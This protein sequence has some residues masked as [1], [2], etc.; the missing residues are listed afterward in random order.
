MDRRLAWT[1]PMTACPRVVL[2]GLDERQRTGD[3]HRVIAVGGEQLALLR[4]GIGGAGRAGS[5]AG[6]EVSDPADPEPAGD[7]LGLCGGR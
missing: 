1:C 2:L 7:V 5:A 4:T 3:E 6:V